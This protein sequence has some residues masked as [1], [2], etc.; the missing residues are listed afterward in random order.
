M[1]SRAWHFL[2]IAFTFSGVVSFVLSLYAIDDG[3]YVLLAL[4]LFY[5]FLSIRAGTL[6]DHAAQREWKRA[7]EPVLQKHAA[8]KPPADPPKAKRWF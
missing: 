3:R 7:I 8:G 1:S 6:R 5:V 2:M 4:A